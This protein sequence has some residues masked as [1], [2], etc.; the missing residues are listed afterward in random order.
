MD[1]DILHATPGRLRVHCRGIDMTRE[2]AHAVCRLLLLHDG[3]AKAELS[4]RTGNLLLVYSR[5]MPMNRALLLL[6]RVS[7][8][9]WTGEPPPP[10]EA[11]PA[12]EQ[13]VVGL[14]KKIAFAACGRILLPP[15][16]RYVL[17]AWKALPHAFK[18]LWSALCGNLD[19]AVAEA[20][21]ILYLLMR[22]EFKALRTLLHLASAAELL[23]KARRSRE[24]ERYAPVLAG[25]AVSGLALSGLVPSFAAAFAH[26]LVKFAVAVARIDRR[27]A[28]RGEGLVLPMRE[29]AKERPFVE[30]A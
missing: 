26:S 21:T 10:P 11:P 13:A 14:G 3:V 24:G 18:G 15:A 29:K 1:F 9:E 23:F 20:A 8:E 22:H 12:F 17:L 28:R 16:A 19:A 7:P 25:A 6:L 30:T 4:L 27:L 2:N 5:V